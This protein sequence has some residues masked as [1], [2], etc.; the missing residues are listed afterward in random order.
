MKNNPFDV[1]IISEVWLTNKT[2]DPRG[3]GSN[4]GQGG[5]GGQHLEKGHLILLWQTSRKA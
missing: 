4:L 3:A 2:S 1:L 5:G